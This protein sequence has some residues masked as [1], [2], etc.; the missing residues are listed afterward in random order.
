MKER[1]PRL[2]AEPVFL[3][4]DGVMCEGR[5]G[6]GSEWKDGVGMNGGVVI[7]SW[8]GLGTFDR[9]CPCPCPGR[10]GVGSEGLG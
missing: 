6:V 5:D 4:H 2:E 1:S 10:R 9:L 7:R 8:R 3:R